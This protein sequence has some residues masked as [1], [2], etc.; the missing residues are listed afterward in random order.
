MGGRLPPWPFRGLA[1]RIG[2]IVLGCSLV[3]SLV[4]T[5]FSVRSIASFL[6][7]RIEEEFPERLRRAGER[8]DAWYAQRELELATFARSEL[9]RRPQGRMPPAAREEMRSYL[10]YVLE[11]SPPYAT[12]ALLDPAG[13]VLLA[14]GA[15][16]ELGA[17]T[18]TRLAALDRPVVVLA[19]DAAGLRLQVVSAPVGRGAGHATLH[20][21]LRPDALAE[22]VAR[23]EDPEAGVALGVLDVARRPLAGSARSAS[24]A[25]PEG[26]ARDTIVVAPAEGG[27]VVAATRPFDRFG[28][29][30][31]VE[32]D[33]D[34]A[35]APISAAVKRALV[36]CGLAVLGSAAAAFALGVWRVRPILSLVEAAGRLAAGETEV[37]VTEASAADEVHTLARSFNEMAERLSQQRGELERRNHELQR[38]NE[39][40]EQLSITDGLTKLHNHRHFQDQYAREARRAGRAGCPLALVLIDIDDFKR[41]NDVL[42][43][44]AGDAVLKAAAGVMSDVVRETDYL[45]R[46]GGEEFAL[47]APQ[48]DLE[49]A[50]ALAEKIRMAVADHSFPVHGPEGPV[51]I[52]V[53]LGVASYQGDPATTFLAADR[54]LYEAK[55]SGKDCVAWA[56]G[57]GEDGR[58]AQRG[59]RRPEPADAS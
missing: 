18:R 42:G 54:A 20:G 8:L 27:R 44:A 9:L 56:R 23:E 17:E 46:Y 10:S 16:L 28:W 39:V 5:W 26:S 14:V 2:W 58:L 31:V 34:V 19:E 47:L 52:T 7:A 3:T 36:V 51:R 13:E 37:R 49:G 29:T 40:L 45:A 59:R 6:E 12:L 25:L 53:S 4:I 21:I 32:Q 48:T 38:A 24:S 15:A 30:L 11:A 33:Y 55:H 50:L 1:A 41:L 43:H 57:D 22:L 35:F